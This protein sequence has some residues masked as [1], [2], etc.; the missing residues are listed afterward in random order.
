[1]A[2]VIAAPCVMVAMTCGVT[3]SPLLAKVAKVLA[4]S[5]TVSDA[6]PSALPT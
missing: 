4:C 3:Y 5:S 6:W 2:V 1:M